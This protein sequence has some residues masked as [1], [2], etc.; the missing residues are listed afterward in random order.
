MEDATDSKEEFSAFVYLDFSQ[1]GLVLTQDVL[2]DDECREAG[3]VG[4]ALS[5]LQVGWDGSKM[6]EGQ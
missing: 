3:E 1:V 6:G 2:L 4:C 5:A